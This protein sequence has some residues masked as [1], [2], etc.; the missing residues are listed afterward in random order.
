MLLFLYSYTIPKYLD[1]VST[2]YKSLLC[3]TEIT[4]SLA[5]MVAILFVNTI[6][7]PFAVTFDTEIKFAFNSEMCFPVESLQIHFYI[8]K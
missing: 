1:F 7:F 2:I 3:L 6:R 4:I 5:I 8:A